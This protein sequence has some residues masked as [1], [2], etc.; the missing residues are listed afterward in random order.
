LG[1]VGYSMAP[2][3]I[4]PQLRLAVSGQAPPPVQRV[5]KRVVG[6]GGNWAGP[7]AGSKGPQ[8][9]LAVWEQAPPAV[10]ER[11]GLGQAPPA[12]PVEERAVLGQAPPAIPVGERV[13]LGQ[14]PPTVPVE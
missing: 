4:P 12:M 8:L 10:E 14:A 1:G 11:M 13:V 6:R 7:G 9:R 3:A 2:G 5:D